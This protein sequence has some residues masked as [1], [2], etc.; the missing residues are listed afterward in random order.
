MTLRG[1]VNALGVF[2]GD[3]PAESY[4]VTVRDNGTG[5]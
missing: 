4:P 5:L 2:H 3:G 1:P